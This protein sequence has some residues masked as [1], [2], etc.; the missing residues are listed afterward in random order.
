MVMAVDAHGTASMC[1]AR[2]GQGDG[3][4]V[5]SV[6]THDDGE[7]AWGRGMTVVK[8]RRCEEA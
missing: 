7:V 5:G 6:G 4:S 3:A 1:V 2:R 8:A